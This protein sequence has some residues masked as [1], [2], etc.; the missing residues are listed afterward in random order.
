MTRAAF[1]DRAVY[2]SDGDA[3]VLADLHVGRGE[4]SDVE[5]PLGEADDLRDRLEALLARYEPR[6]V[7]F[8]GDVL[9]QFSRVSD[10]VVRSVEALTDT[11]R[12]AGARPVFVAG[13]HDTRLDACWNGPIHDGY[14]I[15]RT[16]ATDESVTDDR[17][18]ATDESA[19]ADTTE[20]VD[21][22][23]P[24]VPDGEYAPSLAYPV[25]VRHGHE[26][27]PEAE[28][29]AAGTYLLG[30]DHPT[31]EVEGRRRPCYLH[32]PDAT[33]GTNAVVLPAFNRLPAGV[34]VNGMRGSDF[35]SPFVTNPDDA[36]PLVWD[37]DAGR[38]L[39]FPPLGE[40]RRL[41]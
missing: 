9:H 4:A 29:R 6:E 28:A 36:R 7:V 35:Q 2:L 16:D 13:N 31:I 10:R 19:T 11:C 30:H 14:R 15:E 37:D 33:H 20:T 24:A 40:F 3:L 5:F 22:S 41:L 34:T 23:D 27:P 38:V 8:A 26:T 39:P 25:V 21:P 17:T 32:V 18:A 12:T 1:R